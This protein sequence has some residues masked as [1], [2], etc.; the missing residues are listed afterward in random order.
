MPPLDLTPLDFAEEETIM[1]PPEKQEKVQKEKKEM[2][3]KG[4]AI[5]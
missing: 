1:P 4:E 2:I 5:V 3:I